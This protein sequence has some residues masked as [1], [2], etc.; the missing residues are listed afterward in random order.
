MAITIISN[1]SALRA[2]KDLRSS[3]VALGRTYERLSS[4]LRISRA[5][6]DAAGLAIAENL[7]ADA[8]IA[9]V[10]IRNINDGLSLVSITEGALREIS[11]ILVRMSELS[12]QSQNG[13]ISHKQIS[14][15]HAEYVALG[16][17]INRISQNTKF[18]GM[19][20][21]GS[22]EK[23]AIQVGDSSDPNSQIILNDYDLDTESLGLRLDGPGYMTPD[24]VKDAINTVSGMQ[25]YNASRLEFAKNNASSMSE[26]VSAAASQIRD[27]DVAEEAAELVRLQIMQQAATAVLA[28]AN[29]QPSF[30]LK[31]LPPIV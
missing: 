5:S 15:L 22:S 18:N 1:I 6:D 20:L 19:T 30:A 8:R 26:N 12:I 4:G 3:T 11:N 21:L 27:V 24:V 13:T 29:I 28:Q 17:E 2:Q 14:P 25:M 7:R 10:A 16:S 23:I 31:L 9:N